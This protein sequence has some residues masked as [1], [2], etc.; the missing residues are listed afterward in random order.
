MEVRKRGLRRMANTVAVEVAEQFRVEL[1]QIGIPPR[2]SIL[3]ELEREYQQEDTDFLRLAD[4]IGSDVGISAGLVKVA[5][6]TLFGLRKTVRSVRETLLV[7]GMN[8]IIEIVAALALEKIFGD[9]PRMER[10]WDSSARTARVSAW[11]AN[12]L[13]NRWGIRPEDAYTFGLFRDCGIPLLLQ[14]FPEYKGILGKANTE[15][16]RCF[17]DVEDELIGVNH[18]SVGAEMAHTWR[19]PDEYVHAIRH[20]HRLALSLQVEASKIPRSSWSLV[21]IAQLAEHLIQLKTGQSQSHEWTKAGEVNLLQL[22]LS[23]EDVV[24][25]ERECEGVILDRRRTA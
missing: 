10:F 23:E 18:A 8:Q 5:N 14:P 2:P 22:G 21:A 12:R 25:I 15:Q 20:H 1:R 16:L 17:T 9:S 19:L 4:L 24:A 3:A 7:L 13:R 6:S 11:L